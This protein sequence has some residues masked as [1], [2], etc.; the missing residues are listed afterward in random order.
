MKD[1]GIDSSRIDAE[2][3]LAETIRKPRTYLH[4]NLDETL[5]PRRIDIADARIEL[6]LDR[7]PLAYIVGHKEFYGREFAVSPQVLVP[8]PESESMLETFLEISASDLS[9]IKTLID[10]GTGSGCL[11]ISAK[12]ER[13]DVSVILSDISSAALEVARKNA[14]N[15]GADVRFQ[16]QDLLQGQIEPLNYIFANLPYVDES[17]EVSP[18][19]RH[20]PRLALFAENNGLA[21]I[22][23]LLTQVPLTLQPDGWLFIEADPEQ[24]QKITELAS[25]SNLNL[26]KSAGYCLAFRL[27]VT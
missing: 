9:P 17:W 22:E 21:L 14:H 2:L 5:D 8:R 19:L 23:K 12:L 15:L 24:H 11:G 7:V 1:I 6:R 3:I 10:I 25:K 16:E 4:A 13:P 27:V 26:E 18:E 20:E